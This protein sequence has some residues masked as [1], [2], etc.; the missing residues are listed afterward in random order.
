MILDEI[1]IILSTCIEYYQW[2]QTFVL[3]FSFENK[4]SVN[5]FHCLENFST[6]KINKGCK[7]IKEGMTQQPVLF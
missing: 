2:W 4:K 3:T 6:C 5:M 1:Q 7:D